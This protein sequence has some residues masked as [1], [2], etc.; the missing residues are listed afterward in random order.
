MTLASLHWVPQ[1]DALVFAGDSHTELALP[2][3]EKVIGGTRVLH[4]DQ[5]AAGEIEVEAR[6][7]LGASNPGGPHKASS[8]GYTDRLRNMR[9][10]LVS[11]QV[12]DV[13][14]S[15]ETRVEGKTLHVNVSELKDRLLPNPYI[16]DIQ[17]H[18][19]RPGDRVRIVHAIDVVEPRDKVSGPGAI[20]PGRLGPAGAGGKWHDKQIGGD[21]GGGNGRALH[22]GGIL[23]CA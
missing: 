4:G 18:V 13:V 17:V 20:F 5:D 6:Q 16:E 11:F 2:A 3:V 1:A 9:L 14:F 22:G 7:M 12:N 19:A 21:S 15:P 10:E 23:V 8:D